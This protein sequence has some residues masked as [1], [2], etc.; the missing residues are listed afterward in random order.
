LTLNRENFS[1]LV[2]ETAQLSVTASPKG[3][4]AEVDWT[5]TN[6]DVATV[7]ENGL[8]TAKSPGTATITAT[9]KVDAKKSVS[10]TVTVTEPR[11]GGD[12][13]KPESIVISGETEVEEGGTI[14]LSANVYPLGA[15]QEVVWS[16]SNTEYA[17][18]TENGLLTGLKQGS[19]NVFATSVA[20]ENISGMVEVVI[21]AKQEEEAYP[22]LGNY[23]I[24]IMVGSGAAG[25]YAPFHEYYTYVDEA[26]KQEVWRDVESKFNCKLEVREYPGNAGF[27]T[28]RI[29][30]LIEKATANAAEADIFQVFCGWIKELVDAGVCE[31]LTEYYNKYGKNQMND[32]YKEMATYKGRLYA[33]PSVEFASIN[34]SEGMV[35]NM[36]LLES[37]NIESPAKAF[38]E[39][40]WTYTDFYNYIKEVQSKLG[41]GQYALTGQPYKYWAGMVIA[42]G[43]KL[44]DT[45]TL[46]L[47]IEHQY[48]YDAATVLR[49]LYAEGAWY[50][51]IENSGWTVAPLFNEGQAVFQYVYYDHINTSARFVLE[52]DGVKVDYGFVPYPYPDGISRNETMTSNT[53]ESYFILGKG[54]QYPTGVTAEDIYRAYTMVILDT[55]EH[56]D[57]SENFDEEHVIRDREQKHV[58]DPES[59]ETVLFF[60]P[61]KTLF[62]AIGIIDNYMLEESLGTALRDIVY[63][64]EDF[65]E[66]LASHIE[67]LEAKLR[68]AYG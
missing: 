42:G 14:Q 45:I 60:D 50:P 8:V 5:S 56:M 36:I 41:E 17:T 62:D 57:N 4:S 37:L 22:D 24:Q 23:T 29:S 32:A 18:I 30:W 48:S 68:E 66:T 46:T 19:V 64:G 9:S 13:T 2:D 59:I 26:A 52:R 44:A 28:Q 67:C 55:K 53:G 10:I 1:L 3:A 12:T 38:N 54:R 43:V 61:D 20:D 65:H 47:N 63:R 16:V 49:N 31:D 25:I 15:S 6:P 21:K 34:V 40:H 27:N 7:S 33:F 35:Y 39:D 58:D 51:D 11:V